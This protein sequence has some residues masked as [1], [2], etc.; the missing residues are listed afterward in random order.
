MKILQVCPKF[1]HSV[2]SGST[3]VAY[4]ISTKLASK[5]HL[6]VVYTSDMKDKYTRIGY[7]VE[8][9]NGVMVHRFRSF[10]NIITRE[11]KIIITP[12]IIWSL[13]RKL[14]SFDVIHIHEYRSFQ[15]ILVHY[16]A[17]KYG[18][19]YIL[20]THGSLPKTGAW[21][22]LKY[23]YD[24][25]F[26]YKLL[27]DAS[28]V[29]SLSHM[30][31]DQYRNMGVSEE[32]IKIIPNGIDLTEYDDLP[33]K[34]YFKKRYNISEDVNIIL[35]LGRIHESKGLDLLAEAFRIIT[36]ALDKVMLV[37]VGPDDGFEAKF[38]RLIS[39]FGLTEKV[40][41]TG[42]VEKKEKLAALVDCA[43]FVTPRFSGFPITFLEVCLIGKPIVTTK[44]ELNWINKVGYI[45][46]FSSKTFAEA[47][48][49]LLI[50]EDI[51]EKM[52]QYA[53]YLVINKFNIEN[54]VE[55][56]EELYKEIS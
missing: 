42:F 23:S 35:Y 5:G 44:N 55:S 48:I 51:R 39:D 24:V 17:K 41:L 46:N 13:K 36:K 54:T 15:N 27:R 30:E 40:L 22:K 11:V 7:G 32:K 43:V 14:K 45:V 1:H 34:G 56:L 20:Q 31:A 9:I 26:G 21:R 19:P 52:G 4:N 33:L 53:R 37:M 28:K 8:N 50:N 49:Y 6:V 25:L 16:Y 10:G 38:T 2:A 12:R 47:I 3:K 29:I 18:I